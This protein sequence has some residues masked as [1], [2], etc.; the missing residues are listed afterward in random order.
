MVIRLNTRRCGLGGG[1]TFLMIHF[2]SLSP[3]I[4]HGLVAH[5]GR[6]ICPEIDTSF[7][8]SD[9]VMVAMADFAPSCA[10]SQGHN[11]HSLF[12]V[13]S[14]TVPCEKRRFSQY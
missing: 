11:L 4:G 9:T 3:H 13:A 6:L 10:G 5:P 7:A 14:D 12:C 1:W 8:A 2:P